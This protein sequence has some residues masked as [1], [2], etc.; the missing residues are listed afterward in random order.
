MP[1]EL[2]YLDAHARLDGAPAA[3]L[4]HLAF[5]GAAGAVTAAHD[6]WAGTRAEDLAAHLDALVDDVPGRMRAAGLA[7]WV[8]LGVHPA[9]IPWLGLEAVLA[10]MPARLGRPEVVAVGEVGLFAGGERE[11]D[12]FRRQ[13]ALALDLRLPLVVFV[14]ERDRDRILRRTL[15]IL[16]DAEV[17]GDRALLV[18]VDAKH[19]AMVRG[20]D[21]RVA[22]GGM[23]AAEAAAV[24]ARQGPEGLMLSSELGEGPSDP[25]LPSRTL[26]EMEAAG[27]SRPV[28]RRVAREN[29]EAFFGVR[30]D[31]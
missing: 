16:R 14:P 31:G 2:R 29:A 26:A 22:L 19:V 15:T 11:E 18:R 25:L 24:V 10:A 21:Y 23:T 8:A 7:P 17:P 6:G 12:V 13:I 4:A 30:L 3:D 28:L 1:T 27:L 5:F 9:K 20:L